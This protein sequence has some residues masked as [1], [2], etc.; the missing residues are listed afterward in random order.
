MRRARRMAPTMRHDSLAAMAAHVT[1]LY[2]EAITMSR[3]KVG[4]TFRGSVAVVAAA[5]VLGCNGGDGDGPSGNTGTIQVAVNPASLS[6]EQGSSGT[7]AVTLTRGGGFSAEVAV[8]VS[9]LPS[10]VVVTVTPERL[11]GATTQAQVVVAVAATVAPGT[12]TATVTASAAGVGSAT[13]TYQLT[14]TAAP[15]YTLTMAPA[16]LTVSAGTSGQATVNIDRT[17][18]ATGPVTLTLLSPPAGITGT[19]VANPATTNTSTLT[20]AVA[21]NVVPG[22]YNLTVQGTGT[23]GARTTPLALTVT[24]QPAYTLVANPNAVTVTSGG[25]ANTSIDITRTNFTGGIA[26][27][28]DAPPAGIAA[29][30]TPSPTT[31]NASAMTISVAANVAP[32]AYPLTVKGTAT[33][34]TDR[35]TQ[36]TV[37]VQAPAASYTIVLGVTTGVP[38]GAAGQVGITI[39]RTNFTGTVNLAFE[40]GTTGITGSVTPASTTGNTAVANFTV[41]ANTAPGTYQLA[42]RGTATGLADRVET[43]QLTVTAV[44][45]TIVLAAAP[46]A[47]TVTQGQAGSV[48]LTLTR[49]N[50]TGQVT[51]AATNVPTGVTPSFTP[52]ST[53][54][55][56]SVLGLAVA[57]NAPAGTFPI[58]VTASGAGVTAAVVQVTLTVSPPVAGGNTEF[59]FCSAAETPIYFAAQDGT[60]AWQRVT[61]STA[62]SVTRFTFNITQNRGG[63]MYVQQ[64]TAATVVDVLAVN[65]T[66]NRVT[67]AKD[68][69]E[70]RGP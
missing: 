64:R 50:F 8:A 37:T 61:G 17:N 19:F 55:N 38:Q 12:Y 24:A 32:G 63:V 41:P 42:I 48:N 23:P 47:L 67:L 27:A 33:G 43:F 22:T 21:A 39:T 4:F 70:A 60:G 16:A 49:T 10:G 69:A 31:T 34:L 1:E 53:T 20:V 40:G 52:A 3:L 62:G 11:T 35:T 25:T 13:A 54:G 36:V 6:V 59:Q 45:G 66:T 58:T 30:F 46:T 29:T 65:R 9:G 15:N 2:W 26:L 28:L 68:R 18:F 7:V 51:F 56:T 5:L 44:Q 57:G 14:V